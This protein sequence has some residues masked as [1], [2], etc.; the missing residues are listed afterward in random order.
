MQC[1][2]N[3]HIFYGHAESY[4]IKTINLQFQQSLKS[5]YRNQSSRDYI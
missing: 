1:T 5:L 2:Y 4:G 3:T